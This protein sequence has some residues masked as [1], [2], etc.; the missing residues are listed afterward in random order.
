[1]YSLKLSASLSF[2]FT[3]A[4]VNVRL[5][6]KSV[7]AV[8]AVRRRLG[9]HAEGEGEKVAGGRDGK[10]G[11]GRSERGGAGVRLEQQ[12]SYWLTRIVY[13]RSLGFIYC[14][15]SPNYRTVIAMII[16]PCS[17][18]LTLRAVYDTAICCE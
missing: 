1:M 8:G 4:R 11:D 15:G 3:C 10:G 13:I 5:G 17:H 12:G 6:F 14:K 7:M 9:R 16:R 18:P 2:T